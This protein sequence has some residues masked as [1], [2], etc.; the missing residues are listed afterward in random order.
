MESVKK[1]PGVLWNHKWKVF[2]LLLLGYGAKKLY[3]LYKFVKPFWDL[4]NQLT[5]GASPQT[6]ATES[7]VELTPSQKAL[8]TLIDTYP[9][10]R[11]HLKLFKT[12]IKNINMT[13]LYQPRYLQDNLLEPY[14]CL[15][16]AKAAT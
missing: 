1:V 5:G 6:K 9:D 14:F 16:A 3:D 7:S 15:T 8:K 4:K 13:L 11:Q 12:T 10:L 2:F